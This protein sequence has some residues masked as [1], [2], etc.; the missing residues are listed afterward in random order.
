MAFKYPRPKG[1][2]PELNF[3]VNVLKMKSLHWGYWKGINKL[4]LDNLKK[5]QVNYSKKVLA[6]VPESVE[7]VLDVGAGIGDNAIKLADNKIQVTAVSPEPKQKEIFETISK[8]YKNIRFVQSKYEDLKL[9]EEFDLILMSESSNY[10]PLKIAMRQTNKFLKPGGYLL[11]SGLFRKNNS[12]EY[13]NWNIMFDFENEAKKNGLKL[14]KKE[15]I[16]DLA[17]PTMQLAGNYYYE[18]LQPTV[19]LLANYYKEAFKWKAFL[20]SLFFRKEI[21]LLKNVFLKE[22]PE[23]VDVKKFKNK[24]RYLIYLFQKYDN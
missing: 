2:D 13:A 7:K 6:Y 15:D 8:K 1:L 23:R 12:K 21:G 18:Y 9:N 10:F 5:A 3:Y 24:G 22:I 16:T 11:V 14:I 17:T 20:I 4:S 19:D